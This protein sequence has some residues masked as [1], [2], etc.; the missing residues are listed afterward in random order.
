MGHWRSAAAAVRRRPWWCGISCK[1]RT[2]PPAALAEI[3]SDFNEFRPLLDVIGG[4]QRGESVNVS[5]P[6][7]PTSEGGCLVM[8]ERSICSMRTGLGELLS[9][10]STVCG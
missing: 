7:V 1:R 2:N 10:Y 8:A 9:Q 5:V 6:E 3:S 4:R